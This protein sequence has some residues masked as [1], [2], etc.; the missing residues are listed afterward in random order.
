MGDI[1]WNLFGYI[2]NKDRINVNLDQVKDILE[3]SAPRSIKNPDVKQEN[4]S[5]VSFH[6]LFVG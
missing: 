1:Y 6:Q 3:M 5:L 2:M 4:C